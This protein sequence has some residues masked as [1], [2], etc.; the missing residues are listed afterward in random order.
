MKPS[1]DVNVDE[2]TRG[3]QSKSSEL[4]SPDYLSKSTQLC[5][6][7]GQDEYSVC[8][9]FV[10][11]QTWNEYLESKLESQKSS[12]QTGINYFQINILI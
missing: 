5:G 11:S 2:W 8:S 1:D 10:Y 3:F 7:C 9:S 4:F 6:Y 12:Q